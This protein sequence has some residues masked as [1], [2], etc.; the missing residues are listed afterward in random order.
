MVAKW[1][2][3]NPTLPAIK[4]PKYDKPKFYASAAG[5][6]YDK[7]TA[8]SAKTKTCLSIDEG[9]AFLAKRQDLLVPKVIV[10]QPLSTLF[11]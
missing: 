11:I 8:N 10:D 6:P 9:S 2:K 5:K 7:G 3:D 4:I 1:T